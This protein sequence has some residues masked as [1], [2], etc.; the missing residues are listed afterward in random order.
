MPGSRLRLTLN[1]NNRGHGAPY[2]GIIECDIDDARGE[3]TIAKSL[4]VAFQSTHR[5]EICVGNDCP[6][7]TVARY[8]RTIAEPPNWRCSV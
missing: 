2:Q 8:R 1:A 7:S 5:W 3:V 4:I 6:P